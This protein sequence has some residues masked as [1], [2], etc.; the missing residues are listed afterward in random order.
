VSALETQSRHLPADG[1]T[2]AIELD[3]DLSCAM[4]CRPEVLEQFDVFWVP[5]HRPIPSRLRRRS[6]RFRTANI[7]SSLPCTSDKRCVSVGRP[8]PYATILAVQP[9]A[10]G[11]A[12]GSVIA[13]SVV[14]LFHWNKVASPAKTESGLPRWL[15][16]LFF[17]THHLPWRVRMVKRNKHRPA[18][19]ATPLPQPIRIAPR[20]S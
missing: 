19:L 7:S 6:R 8:R 9:S 2:T 11:L 13:G 1:R 18:P 16:V 3:G 15:W 17:G 14:Q 5:I 4:P 10:N 20:R 12:S